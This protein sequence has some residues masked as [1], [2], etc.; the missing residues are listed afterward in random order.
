MLAALAAALVLAAP[1]PALAQSAGDEQYQDPFGG[2]SNGSGGGSGSQTPSTPSTPAPVPST[3]APTSSSSTA[4][5]A[6]TAQAVPS[7][8]SRSQLPYTGSPVAAGWLAA[9]G[10]TMVAGGLTLRLRLRER[11]RA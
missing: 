10:A 3:P 1:A 6:T 5:S 7:A 8:S 11:D 2:T 4:P 9:L